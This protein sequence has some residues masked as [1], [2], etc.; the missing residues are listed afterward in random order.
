[1]RFI[2]PLDE[3]LLESV[4]HRHRLVVTVEENSLAGGFGSAVVEWAARP[5]VVDHP[6]VINLGI[7]DKFQEHASRNELLADM[8]LTGE[9]LAQTI[10]TYLEN[11]RDGSQTQSAS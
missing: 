8:G 3:D 2:K 1:M 4:W 9:G 7:P 11:R 10:A 5:E 6:Q